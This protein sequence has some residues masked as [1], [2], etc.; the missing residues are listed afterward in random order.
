MKN[1]TYIIAEIGVNHNGN[2]QL[3]KKMIE[4]QPNKY[5]SNE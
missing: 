1:I 3:A 2:V 4:L 5:V